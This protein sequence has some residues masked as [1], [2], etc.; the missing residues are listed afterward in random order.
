MGYLGGFLVTATV[1]VANVEHWNALLASSIAV[2]GGSCA[3]GTRS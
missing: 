1:Q 2:A 3:S